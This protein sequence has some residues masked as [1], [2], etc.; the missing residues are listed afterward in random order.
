MVELRRRLFREFERQSRTG[1]V[2]PV[3]LTP[4]DLRLALRRLIEAELPLV[5]VLSTAE[6]GGRT[7]VR[8]L[9]SVAM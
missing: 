7:R 3:L 6:V 8:L 1:R 2:I 9:A 5:A 4:P